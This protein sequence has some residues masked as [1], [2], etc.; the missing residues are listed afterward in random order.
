MPKTQYA[1]KPLKVQAEQYT[2]T[3]ITGVCTCTISPLF[4]DGR[5]HVHGEQGQQAITPTDWIVFNRT[6]TRCEGVWTD[7][8]FREDF[9]VGGPSE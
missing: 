9:N 7:A 4:A 5:P 2:G 1:A 6:Q 8:N 3:P